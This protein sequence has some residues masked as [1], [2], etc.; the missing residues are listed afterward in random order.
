MKKDKKAR[1]SERSNE[2]LHI[3]QENDINRC[4]ISKP[5]L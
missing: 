2:K 3:R 4:E 1:N 5:K